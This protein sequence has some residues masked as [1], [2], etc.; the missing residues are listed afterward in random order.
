VPVAA[1]PPQ[2]LTT[3]AQVAQV[4]VQ[5]AVPLLG[6]TAM[7]SSAAAVATTTSAKRERGQ[8]RVRLEQL[9]LEVAALQVRDLIG[10]PFNLLLAVAL[11]TRTQHMNKSAFC[12]W[13]V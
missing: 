12:R 9:K 6:G 2:L 8:Q 5:N 4:T 11:S 7:A 1:L 13:A 10:T 3:A